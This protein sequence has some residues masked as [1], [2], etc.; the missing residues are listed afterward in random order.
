MRAIEPSQILCFLGL[1]AAGMVASMGLLALAC[2]LWPAAG[3]GGDWS[4]VMPVIFV[5]AFIGCMVAVFRLWWR[6]RPL[7]LGV[8]EPGSAGEFTYHVY[9]LFYLIV[10][11]PVM[12]CQLLPVPL[13]RLMY[14]GL[15]ACMGPNSYTGG[16]ILDPPLVSIGRDTL[17]G[18]GSLLVPHIIEGRRLEHHR[19]SIGDRVTVGANATVMAG[20]CIGDDA[21]VAMH[22]VVLAGTVIP[23]GEVWGGV[24][25]RRLRSP[26][27]AGNRGG[28]RGIA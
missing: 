23:A 17:L 19:I 1:L 9:I 4:W 25:A 28:D 15:G 22:S 14:L 18:M 16:L 26:C 10:F 8:I 7:P 20:A 3:P 12:R 13:N 6:W 5:A 2:V 24:P 27:D 11:Y 21:V